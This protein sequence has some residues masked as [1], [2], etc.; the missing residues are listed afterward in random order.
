MA[1]VEYFQKKLYQSL[2]VPVSRLQPAA[3]GFNL[4]RAAEI[5]R[6]EVK[7]TKFA[8]RLRRRFSHIFLKALE[9][10]LILKGIIAESDWPEISNAINFDYAIDNHFE[11]FK[12][13]EV[14]QNRLQNLQTVLP[15]IGK[16]YSDQWVRKNILRQTDEEIEQM[17]NEINDEGSAVQDDGDGA[18][19]AVDDQSQGQSAQ[20]AQPRPG[21]VPNIDGAGR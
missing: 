10:Q 11:E 19:N 7:F 9:K 16:Y 13:A 12:D 15:Y 8:G 17:M 6:A 4:G 14:I 18:S 20:Q 1:D 5:T 3:A 2:N 21:A